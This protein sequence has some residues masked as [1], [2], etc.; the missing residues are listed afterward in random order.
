MDVPST[1]EFIQKEGWFG[2]WNERN[3]RLTSNSLSKLKYSNVT[4]TGLKKVQDFCRRM[5]EVGS[6]RRWFCTAR[7]NRYWSNSIAPGTF[8]GSMSYEMTWRAW[9]EQLFVPPLITDEEYFTYVPLD[10]FDLPEYL[11]EIL[12]S[13]APA[14]TIA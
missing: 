9:R 4:L 6:D 2:F 5:V 8:I 14:H 10:M 12:T 11:S 1:L 13:P 7:R 3:L